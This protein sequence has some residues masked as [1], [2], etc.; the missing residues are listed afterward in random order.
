M[1]C[2]ILYAGKIQSLKKSV[3][4][5]DKKKKKEVTE[6]ITRLE[7]ELEKLQN[8]EFLQLKQ[9]GFMISVIYLI[10]CLLWKCEILKT[11]GVVIDHLIPHFKDRASRPT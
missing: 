11:V 7:L 1:L 2:I 9:V 3:T 6:E 10:H 4:K 5:G 8:E